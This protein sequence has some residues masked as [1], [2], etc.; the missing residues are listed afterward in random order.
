MHELYVLILYFILGL[1]VNI[2]IGSFFC[3]IILMISDRIK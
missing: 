3:I 2:V 1:E